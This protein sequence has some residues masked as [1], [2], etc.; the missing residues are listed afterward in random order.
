MKDA[1]VVTERPSSGAAAEGVPL[2]EHPEWSDRLP[3]LCQGVTAAR[4]GPDAPAFDLAIFGD[5]RGHE[6]MQHWTALWRA[7]GF[8]R[9]VHGRQVHGAVTRVHDHGPPGLH[10]S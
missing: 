5:G 7:T 2:W 9:I 8:D 4:V 1:Q 3:W 6:V 10:L